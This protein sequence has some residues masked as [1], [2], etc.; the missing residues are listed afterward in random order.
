MANAIFHLRQVLALD[1]GSATAHYHLGRVLVR[2]DSTEAGIAHY[3]QALE[4]EPE[5]RNL[6]DSLTELSN[7][8]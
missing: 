4:I 3:R 5:N 8:R 6:Q 7:W 1:P 2:L